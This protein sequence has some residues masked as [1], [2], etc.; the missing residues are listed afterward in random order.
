LRNTAVKKDREPGKEGDTRLSE[1]EERV[2]F[3]LIR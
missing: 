3:P 2:F 1:E